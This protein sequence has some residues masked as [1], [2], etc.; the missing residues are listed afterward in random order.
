MPLFQAGTSEQEMQRCDYGG[1]KKEVFERSPSFNYD[2]IALHGQSRRR[3]ACEDGEPN[4]S[5][6]NMI[7][8]CSPPVC[9]KLG[10]DQQAVID[11]ISK[12]A[13]R[14]WAISNFGATTGSRGFQNR[15]FCKA[16]CERQDQGCP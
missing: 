11:I 1:G 7:G 15:V 13:G 8:V 14:S 4:S 6:R 5:C 3:T 10:L 12:G 9:V 2:N 16:L